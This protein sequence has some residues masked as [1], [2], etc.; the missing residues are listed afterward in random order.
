VD[1]PVSGSLLVMV[2]VVVM[3]GDDDGDGGG[4][5]CRGVLIIALAPSR[6]H[7]ADSRFHR[8]PWRD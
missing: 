2:M 5:G 6:D 7:R 4:G 1:Y 8:D 3:Y